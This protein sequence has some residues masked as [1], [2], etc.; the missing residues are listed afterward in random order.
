MRRDTDTQRP[1]RRPNGLLLVL[2]AGVAVVLPALA[3]GAD[4]AARPGAAP[5]LAYTGPTTVRA[6][7]T[8]S[9]RTPADRNIVAV[10]FRIDGK[11]FVSDTV[12]PYSA[13]VLT[14]ELGPGRH[15]VV[16]ELVYRSGERR[17]SKPSR[18]DVPRRG[19]QRMLTVSPARFAVA[20]RRMA[21]G[22]VAV[23][24]LPGR[25]PIRELPIGGNVTLVG[26]GPATVLE[27][28][29]DDHWGGLVLKGSD[30]TVASLAIRSASPGARGR[31]IAV[32]PGSQRVMLRRLDISRTRDAGV[33]V[34][35]AASEVTV[36]DSRIDG[37]TT[38]VAGV[39][40]RTGEGNDAS[41]IRTRI[42]RFAGY[43]ILFSQVR[44]DNRSAGLRN[45]ALDNDIADIDAAEDTDGRS[46]GGIWSGGALASIIGNRVTRAGWDGIE[47]VGS[48]YEVVIARNAIS[49]TRVGVYLE[50]ATHSSLISRNVISD[51]RTGINVEWFYDGIGSADNQFVQNAIHNA[52]IGI[53]VD[54][55]SDRNLLSR[56]RFHYGGR[57]SIIL[58]GASQ[59]RVV[60]N[61]AC[62]AEGTVVREQAADPGTGVSVRGTANVIEANTSV[63]SC[64]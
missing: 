60:E 47:T 43:G 62:G 38:A 32:Q 24:L 16:V 50:H 51:V 29:S 6:G 3:V 10:T 46:K 5:A 39:I 21:A 19:G 49:R 57:P 1:S 9:A 18:I 15:R 34:W 61:V 13:R 4:R 53:F 56:N 36:Q 30:I 17:R 40:V 44:H 42:T 31:A 22:N 23:R 35:G 48:S 26:S 59:N 52:Q 37:G 45:V 55:G 28:S 58:Q 27:T 64:G 12:P 11:P 33:Y 8:L 7:T 63:A 20:A 54:Y 2:L 41:V 14:G 25:Y